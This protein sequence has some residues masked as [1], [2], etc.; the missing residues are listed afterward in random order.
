MNQASVVQTDLVFKQG[1][2]GFDIA[3]EILDFDL[4]GVTPQIVFRKPTGAVE[5]TSLTLSGT[6]YTYTIQGTEL[7]TPGICICD[8][9]LKTSTT[10][11]ISTASFM[12][13]VDADTLDGLNEHANSY[14]DTIEQIW[15]TLQDFSEDSEAWAVGTKNGVPVD[16][17]EPQHANNAKWYAD[18]A[19]SDAQSSA[20]LYT[21]FVNAMGIGTFQYNENTGH[22]LY[23][24]APQ[25]TITFS[26]SDGHLILN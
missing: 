22:L 12:Y 21:R 25:G 18:R 5:S 7:D 16:T 10:Q 23:T 8:I 13:T 6:T 17:S 9:K 15:E 2:C 11:R 4:T 24:A 1:D 14:S 19:D 20:E 3:I 26:L